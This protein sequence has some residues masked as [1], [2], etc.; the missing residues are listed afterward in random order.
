MVVD[1]AAEISLFGWLFVLHNP[2]IANNLQLSYRSLGAD[3][4]SADT[5]GLGSV[6]LQGANLTALKYPCKVIGCNRTTALSAGFHF[7]CSVQEC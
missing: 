7:K 4:D 5:S 3:G 6:L 2:I 1:F